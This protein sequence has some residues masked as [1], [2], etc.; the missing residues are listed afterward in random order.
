MTLRK[1]W[2]ATLSSALMAFLCVV[3]GTQ[4]AQAYDDPGLTAPGG[5]RIAGATNGA[6]TG[7]V[8]PAAWT[9]NVSPLLSQEAA[10]RNLTTADR[11]AALHNCP[12]LYACVA[13]GQGDGRH[14]VFFLYHCDTRTLTNFIDAG[15][16]TNRQSPGATV[17]FTGPGAPTLAFAPR[18]EPYSFYPLP[19]DRIDPC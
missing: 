2:L 19:Y 14:T 8:A 5:N 17:R 4:A 3:G 11:N 10:G 1:R 12:R 6:S 18:V 13:V 16:I 9:P 7:E 15:A